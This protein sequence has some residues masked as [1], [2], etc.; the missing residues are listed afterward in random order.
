MKDSINKV[1]ESDMTAQLAEVL[2]RINNAETMR[3]FLRDV[4]TE[5]EITEI[6][7]RFQAAR[8]LDAG[9][10]YTDIIRK[11][12]LSSRTVARISEWR[13]NGRGGYAQ[14]INIANHHGHIRPARA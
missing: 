3:D 9:D 10:K 12:R 14:A 6:S 7:A 2:A 4:L 1:W 8:M 13:Q 5:K 11:T